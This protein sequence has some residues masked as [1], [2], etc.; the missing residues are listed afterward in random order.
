MVLEGQEG[1]HG[2]ACPEQHIRIGVGCRSLPFWSLCQTQKLILHPCMSVINAWCASGCAGVDPSAAVMHR[3]VEQYVQLCQTETARA[4]LEVPVVRSNVVCVAAQ[5]QC[6]DFT[7][8]RL[9]ALQSM[10]DHICPCPSKHMHVV[11]WG[12]CAKAIGMFRKK[13]EVIQKHCRFAT[14]TSESSIAPLQ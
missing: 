3:A 8:H 11:C 13:E 5:L 12:R 6:D 2:A 4:D 9:D 14:R 7:R 1:A 10:S